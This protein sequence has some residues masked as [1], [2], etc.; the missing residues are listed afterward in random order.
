MPNKPRPDNPHRMVRVNDELWQA[1]KA[2]SAA[3]GTTV[4]A[5]IRSALTR[6]VARHGEK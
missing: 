6:Y 5:V 1:A 4:S 3:N 2:A